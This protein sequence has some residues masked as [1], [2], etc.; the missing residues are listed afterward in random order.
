MPSDEPLQP[1]VSL[2]RLEPAKSAPAALR[3]RALP[4][5]TPPAADW[6]RYLVALRRYKWVVVATSL[7]GGFAGFGAGRYLGSEYN[8]RATIWIDVPDPRER[9]D[10]PLW[11]GQ[12][13]ISSGWTDLLETSAVLEPV[14]RQRRLYLSPDD[15]ADSAVLRPF[16]IK[17]Q[18]RPGAFDFTVA[19]SGG[20]FTLTSADGV[21]EQGTVGDSVGADLGFLW[22][23]APDAVA[24]GHTV[25]FTITAP[26]DAAKLLAKQLV[27][28]SDLGDNFIQLELRGSSPTA[29]AATVNAVADRF[30]ELATELKRRKLT[31]LT[32][33]LSG[34]LTQAQ[35]KLQEAEA[36]LKR[37][38][39]SAV[40]QFAQGTTGVVPGLEKVQDPGFAGLLD[41]K[42]SRE[43]VRRDREALRRVLAQ[44]Q[45]S[46]LSVD[47]LGMIG[48]VQRSLELSE[49]LKELTGK[50]AELR[51]V[52]F[53]Y[54]DATPAVRHLADEVKLLER[55]TIPRLAT[56]LMNELSVRE[57]E[58]GKDVE[59]ASGNLRRVSP[60]AVEEAA[61]QRDVMS[62]E[63]LV[64]NIRQRYEEARLA[65]ASSIPDVRILDR[66][67]VPF[68]PAFN[69]MPVLLILGL[70]GGFGAGG[71]AAVLLDHLDRKVREPDEVTRVMGLPILGAVP[72]LKQRRNGAVHEGGLPIIEAIRGIR[73]S[74]QVAHGAAGPLVCTITSPGRSDGK[75][76]LAS[77]LALGLADSGLRT[78]LIDGDIRRGQ[79]HR[80]L[81]LARKPGLTDVLAGKATADD[82]VR[83]T[84][85]PRVSF[86]ACGTRR[87]SGPELLGSAAMRAFLTGLRGRFDAILVDSP[88]LDAGVDAYLLGTLTSNMLLVL[89]TGVTDRELAAAKLD[90]LDRLPVRVLGAVLN[91]VE[92]RGAYRY[93]AYSIEG[94]ELKEERDADDGSEA[95]RVLVRNPK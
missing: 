6:W 46:G 80:V 72:H 60:L 18:V 91:D 8:A 32:G 87:F 54:T 5:P 26:S 71:G 58:V 56:A 68:L 35:G 19:K 7:M 30:E 92:P 24:P 12:L 9:D 86:V 10:G 81:A 39:A 59:S 14:V 95:A 3:P 25:S 78:V 37:F 40:T 70:M 79:L 82:V 53:R 88:P 22:A 29:V 83:A 44:A 15:P 48:S 49:A 55:Q 85:F 76:F 69:L 21:R 33:I 41:L 43:Q 89:R 2:G 1:A 42:V 36:A 45:D 38:R 4:S 51:A 23:P 73:L 64:A 63:Q 57:S 28:K 67:A 74:V 20:T 13:R 66:A 47:A 75:S 50:Q 84:S 65:D 93:Y 16:R 61:L 52:R 31:E 62:A 90:V 77:N 94:Y 34:Q 27:V 11:T 17:D